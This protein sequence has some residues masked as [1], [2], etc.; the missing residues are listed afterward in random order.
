MKKLALLAAVGA[1]GAGSAVAFTVPAGADTTPSSTS[2]TT[3]TTTTTPTTGPG[4]G[5]RAHHVRYIAAGTLV[6]WSLTRN[7]GG[8]WSGTLTVDVKRGN[9]HVTKGQNTYTVS[10]ARVRVGRRARP[11][12]AGD[13]VLLLGNVT[14]LRKRCDQSGFT[15]VIT[16]HRIFVRAPKPQPTTTTTTTTSS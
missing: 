14:A 12:A 10:D 6:S 2:T 16:I 8:R 13:R 11:P 4:H 1:L 7:V 5:C 15:P 9:R 3:T